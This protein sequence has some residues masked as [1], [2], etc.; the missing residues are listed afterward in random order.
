MSTTTPLIEDSKD[1]IVWLDNTLDFVINM[2]KTLAI[3]FVGIVVFLI[4][5]TG[6]IYILLEWL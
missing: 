1:N 5:W 2:A 4:L 6:F 3:P